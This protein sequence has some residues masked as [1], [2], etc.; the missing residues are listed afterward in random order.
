MLTPSEISNKK[1][2]KTRMS[3][4]YKMDDVDDFLDEVLASFEALITEKERLK[5]QN[6]ELDKKI[7]V[8]AEKLE[9]YRNDED[10][11][12]A[13]LMGAQRLGDSIVKD[14]KTK[15]DI[16]LRDASIKADRV[17]D[18]AKKQIS[19]EEMT[20]I[21]LKKEVSKFK[22]DVLGL[23]KK[24]IEVISK[25]PEE[26]FIEEKLEEEEVPAP[27]VEEPAAEPAAPVQ[28]SPADEPEEEG[29]FRVQPASKFGALKF[30]ENYDLS[31]DEEDM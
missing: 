31:S 4:G 3:S 10:S 9:E 19:R 26:E 8:L 17:I 14:A 6:A 1:F 11:L 12:R 21:T 28:P 2:E 15:A 7:E 5:A 20:L 27:V 25:L 13:A 22:A 18:S 30:G 29:T 23:Y 24:H 16:L